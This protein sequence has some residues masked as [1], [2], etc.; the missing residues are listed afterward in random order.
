MDKA[1]NSQSPRSAPGAVDDRRRS[2]RVPQ[3]GTFHIR[4]LLKDGIGAYD[5]E[6]LIQNIAQVAKAFGLTRAPE[7]AEIYDDRFL[8]PREE[9]M[10]VQ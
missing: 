6:R 8:P 7:A 5:R 10:P 9:R 1:A 3:K 4:P 2:P